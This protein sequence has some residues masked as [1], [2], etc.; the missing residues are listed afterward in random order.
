MTIF[1]FFYPIEYIRKLNNI[2]NLCY[3]L[4]IITSNIKISTKNY[5]KFYIFYF[6]FYQ[7]SR[8]NDYN[9]LIKCE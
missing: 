8:V 7:K 9:H 3:S 1:T 2:F 6:I 4:N 5:Q